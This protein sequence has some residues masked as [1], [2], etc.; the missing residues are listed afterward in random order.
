MEESLRYALIFV[1]I[2]ITIA[3]FYVS[4]F[5]YKTTDNEGRT[6]YHISR[7]I[8]LFISS[9][10]SLYIVYNL[11]L[12]KA[13]DMKLITGLSDKLTSIGRNVTTFTTK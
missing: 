1:F 8:G 7:S 3:C 10:F 6:T 5:K 9:F 12:N 11:V 4:I 13:I 2:V